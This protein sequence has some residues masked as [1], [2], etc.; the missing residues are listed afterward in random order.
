MR[1]GLTVRNTRFAKRAADAHNTISL[2]GGLVNWETQYREFVDTGRAVV[3]QE[4]RHRAAKQE[5]RVC[6]GSPNTNE[7]E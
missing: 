6:I 5:F 3:Y 2:R 7:S 4:A 1:D